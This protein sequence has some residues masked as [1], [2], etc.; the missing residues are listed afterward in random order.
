MGRNQSCRAQKGATRMTRQSSLAIFDITRKSIGI[1]GK[2]YA[3]I[4][5]QSI[6]RASTAKASGS[7]DREQ[8]TGRRWLALDANR[9]IV[10]LKIDLNSDR[11]TT[12]FRD[13]SVTDDCPLDRSSAR[14]LTTPGM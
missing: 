9:S 12:G 6:D 8:Y 5:T 10:G 1:G 3:V 11:T 7:R 4:P 2:A 13:H 14:R